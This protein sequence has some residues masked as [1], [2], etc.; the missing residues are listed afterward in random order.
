MSK[1][2]LIIDDEQDL[3]ELVQ[4]SLNCFTNWQVQTAATGAEGIQK[5][6]AHPFDAILLDISMPNMNGFQVFEQLQSYSAT[7]AIP[8]I[9][10][11]A[12]VQ[13]NDRRRFLEMNVA[14]IITKPFASETIA[15]HVAELLGWQ[16]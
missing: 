6:I 16:T 12:K 5:A 1:N 9:L 8:V 3:R 2:I 11:T 13:P 4:L 7:Q 10:L 15:A 14:G